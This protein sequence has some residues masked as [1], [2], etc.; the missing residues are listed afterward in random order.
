MQYVMF[1]EK[2]TNRVF[3]F[4]TEEQF[5]GILEMVFKSRLGEQY[6]YT[7]DDLKEFNINKHAIDRDKAVK[8]MKARNHQQA[9]YETY[10]RGF[11]EKF[12]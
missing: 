3:V 12:N 5:A 7:N 2:F 9:E 4:E 6:W 10:I 1:V 8:F 11:V